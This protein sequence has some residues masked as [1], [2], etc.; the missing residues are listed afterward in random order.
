MV[1]LTLRPYVKTGDSHRHEGKGDLA[2]RWKDQVDGTCLFCR[3]EDVLRSVQMTMTLLFKLVNG[4]E[5]RVL[6][7]IVE[8]GWM[9]RPRI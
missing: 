1:R 3:T 8:S 4:R 5:Q 7:A 6:E 2:D 9:N